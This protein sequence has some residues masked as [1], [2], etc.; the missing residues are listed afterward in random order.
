M[1]AYMYVCME[2]MYTCMYVCMYVCMYIPQCSKLKT[3]TSSVY[4]YALCMY[5]C[6]YVCM[7]DQRERGMKELGCGGSVNGGLLYFRNTSQLRQ[8]FIPK[9]WSHREEILAGHGARS[10]QEIMGY[11]I[12]AL[13]YAYIPI[14]RSKV[15]TCLTH[16]VNKSK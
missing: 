14:K 15:R 5:V 6:M 8:K 10:D 1:Y 2:C 9:M 3:N 11:D 12:H 16:A 13:H 7:Y 4:I